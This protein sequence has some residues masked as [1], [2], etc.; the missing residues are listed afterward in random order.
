MLVVDPVT[1]PVVAEAFEMRADGATFDAVRTFL[2]D[3]G[4]A[5]SYHGTTTMLATRTVLGELH[6]GSYAPNL[7]A[8]E[9]IVDR[10]VWDR[11]QRMV[12]SVEVRGAGAYVILPGSRHA[13]GVAYEWADAKRPWSTPL[14]PVPPALAPTKQRPA[15]SGMVSLAIGAGARNSTLF[16]LAGTPA[17]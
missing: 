14:A 11:V 12:V 17:R 16:S 9:A 7:T 5:R 2:A 13:S 8:H 6:F 1:V 3:H 15:P 10:A 4:I